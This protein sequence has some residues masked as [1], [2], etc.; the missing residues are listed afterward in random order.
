MNGNSNSSEAPRLVKSDPEVYKRTGNYIVGP[1]ILENMNGEVVGG[2]RVIYTLSKSPIDVEGDGKLSL[3]VSC[4][5]YDRV[6]SFILDPR[7][8]LTIDWANNV[9]QF[10]SRGIKYKIRPILPE[11]EENIITF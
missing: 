2:L 3:E 5:L 11:D 6:T 9:G 10:S 7:T 8:D 4:G 1:A